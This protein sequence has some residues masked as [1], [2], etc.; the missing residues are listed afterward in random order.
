MPKRVNNVVVNPRHSDVGLVLAAPIMPKM[1]LR[2]KTGKEGGDETTEEDALVEPKERQ[3]IP[4]VVSPTS[5]SNRLEHSPNDHVFPPQLDKETI[6]EWFGLHLNPAK[7]IEFMCGLM[8]MCQ[9]LELR[10]L[11][12]YLEDLARKDYHVLRDFEFRANNPNELGILTDLIDPVVRSK[13]LVCLSLLGSDSRECAG[14]LF[15]ILS[16]VDPSLFYKKYDYSLPSFRDPQHHPDGN[17]CKQTCAVS[18]TEISPGPL[19]QLALLFSMASLHPAFHFH[20]RETLRAQLDKIELAIEEERRQIRRNAQTTE[21]PGHKVDYLPSS[22]LGEC[23]DSH[24]PCQSRRSRRGAIQKEAVHIEAIVLK[25]ISLTRIDK[26]YNFEVKWSD[27]SSSHVTKTHLELENFLFKLP[28]DQ[29][30]DSFEKSLLRLLS[31][32]HHYESRECEKSLREKFLAA[33][34]IFRQTKRVCS[35]FNCDSSYSTKPSSCR[36]NCQLGKNLQGDCSDASSQ[37]EESYS[38]GHK[39]KHGAKSAS[40]SLPSAKG[41][42]GD[43]W[44]GPHV[45]ELSGS[46]ER[47]KR[48]FNLRSVPEPEQETEKRN[49]PGAKAKSR[50]RGT[51]KGSYLINGNLAPTHLPQNKGLVAVA[52][53]GPDTFG[54]TSSESYSSPSSP[55]HRGVESL[56]SE[57]DNNKDTDSHSDD[58]FQVAGPNMFFA[59]QSDPSVVENLMSV[60][61]LSPNNQIDFT[62]PENN[63]QFPPLSFMHPDVLPNGACD[64]PLTVPP[65]PSQ[66]VLPDGKPSSGPLMMPMPPGVPVMP[67]PGEPEKRD[68][69]PT[70]GIP[71]MGFQPGVQ[72]LVQRFKTALPHNQGGHDGSSESTSTP[73][74][75]QSAQQAPVRPI[76]ATSSGLAMYPS[77]LPCQDA[78]ALSSGLTR[79]LPHGEASHAKHPG[80]TLGSALPSAFTLPPGGAPAASGHV[81]AGVP[82]A[83]PTHTPGPAPSP[84]LAHGTALSDCISYSNAGASCGSGCDNPIALPQSQQQQ[85]PPQPPAPQPPQQQQHLMGC[86]TCGCHNNCGSRGSGNGVSGCQ[87]PLFFPN[88]QMAAAVR[89]VFSV[90]PP[91]FQLT[92]LCINSYLTQGQPPH[93]ANGAAALPPFYPNAP[94]PG[95]PSAY[96][97]IHSH[98]HSHADVSSHMLSTQVVAAAAAAAASYNLQQQMTPVASFQRIY[99]HVYPNPL[100]ML[101]AASLGGGGVN[102]KNGS[103]S[104]S[105]CGVSGHYAQDCNQPSIDSAQQGGFRLKYAASHVAEALDGAD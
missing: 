58:S 37:D 67:G 45:A 79:S 97:P 95:H 48:G 14:I 75:S 56:D 74:G 69:M 38:Q 29:C 94:P 70:F 13:L 21:L 26:E 23:A 40:Q 65:L 16:H 100:G 62:G 8:H 10:F 24:P 18:N 64:P 5:M 42:Q 39:K 52:C 11:G 35:F 77:S 54:E 82:P 81:Q 12:S 7:R 47:R 87:A 1:K 90:P 101:Q 59:R 96:G 60:H 73:V 22:S 27:S 66:S 20:Q 105:N 6:F 51:E 91:L 104:C 63:L 15:R 93:Q 44:R 92:S 71:S 98:P 2:M 61:P 76:G 19:D 88:H 9:P 103:V 57:D 53:S 80:L 99:R 43:S 46:S 25:C 85:V 68:I 49:H 89:Q 30:T 41:P 83:V 31:Q 36:C 102:K 4:S 28:K 34:P 32:G 33:P 84:A 86:G 17:A 50:D 78:A 72:P 3:H 55:Q